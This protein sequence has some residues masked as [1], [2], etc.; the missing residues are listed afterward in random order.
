[1][2]SIILRKRPTLFFCE[3]H[4]RPDHPVIKYLT[5]KKI[6]VRCISESKQAINRIITGV[7]DLV[8]LD[9][10]LPADGGYEVCKAVRPYFSGLILLQGQERDEA[11]QLLAFE[12]AADDYIPLPVSPALL[13][14]RIDAHLKRSQ[15]SA[16]KSGSRQI[17]VGELVVDA[18]LRAVSLAGRPI[19]LT[20][21]QFELLWYL[22]KRSGCVVP[23]EE[24]YEALYQQKYNGFDRC[25]D[26]YISRIRHQLGDDAESPNFLKTVRGVGYLFVGR[27][28]DRC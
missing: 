3:A 12:H 1:M 16:G 15:S 6:K 25:V 7:P 2:P 17:R 5:A 10:R 13:A 24:L 20:S 23:R 9:T 4:T 28:G 14:A 27:N 22:A 8:L 11:A 18:S 26:V 21:T 19:D